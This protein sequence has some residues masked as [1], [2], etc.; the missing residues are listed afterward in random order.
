MRRQM[1]HRRHISRAQGDAEPKGVDVTRKKPSRT[2]DRQYPPQAMTI[3][4]GEPGLLELVSHDGIGERLSGLPDDEGRI[5]RQAPRC[6]DWAND[7]SPH[8]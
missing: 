4:L 1:L 7:R 3:S 6:D 5:G 8:P 2:V